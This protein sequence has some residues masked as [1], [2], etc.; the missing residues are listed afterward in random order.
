MLRLHSNSF[1][2]LA[3]FLTAL[4]PDF[5]YEG[6]GKLQICV[7]WLLPRRVCMASR[8]QEHIEQI[9]ERCLIAK[10][11]LV[12]RNELRE[13]KNIGA[14]DLDE[15]IAKF[16]LQVFLTQMKNKNSRSWSRKLTI[17]TSRFLVPI[18]SVSLSPFL[19]TK[20]FIEQLDISLGFAQC[21]LV[22]FMLYKLVW[23]ATN[24]H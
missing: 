10:K 8:K 7:S 6:G 20:I 13:T 24:Q 14:R 15:L 5:S 4:P 23:L 16:L 12:S 9:T 21:V 11:K 17:N 18:F 2:D 3:A 22:F 1:S 19:E